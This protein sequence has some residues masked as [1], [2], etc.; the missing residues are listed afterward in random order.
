MGQLTSTDVQ[1]WLT[2]A[3]QANLTDPVSLR[4]ILFL[5]QLLAALTPKETA[6]LANYPNPFNPET[7]I[8]YQLATPADVN[9]SIYAA[10]GTLVRK[11]DLRH[12]PAGMYQSRNRAAYWDGKN[13]VGEAV[14]SGIYFYTL[15]AADFSATRKMLILK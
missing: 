15:Q 8:P 5:K 10:D 9:I 1:Q 6:L 7:W 13:A 12:Q 11:L 14:A 3:Q 2:L 4:G